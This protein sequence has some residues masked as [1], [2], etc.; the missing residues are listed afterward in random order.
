MAAY[1][2]C[3]EATLDIKNQGRVGYQIV[4]ITMKT[5]FQVSIK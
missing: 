5:K 3:S 4:L 2:G 1:E